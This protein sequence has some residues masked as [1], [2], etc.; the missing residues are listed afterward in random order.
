MPFRLRE[1]IRRL[2]PYIPGKPIEEVQR[3]LG[4]EHVVKLASNENPL[5]PSP[6]AVAAIQSA[7][8]GVSHYPDASGYELKS[9]L[10]ARL[11]LPAPQIVLGNGSDELIH[12]LSILLLEEGDEAVMADPGFPRYEASAKVIGAKPIKVS[13]DSQETHD[14]ERMVGAVNEK[15]RIVW[16]AN[17]NNPTGTIVRKQALDNYFKRVPAHVL[18]VL[19]EAYCDFVD[20][21]SYRTALDYLNEGRPAFGLRTFSKSYGL[22]GM[23]VGYGFGPEELCKPLDCIRPPFNVNSLAQKAALAAL[24]D[25]EH[26]EKTIR[27]SRS[28]VGRL[29]SCLQRHGAKVA[30]SFGNFIWADLGRNASGVSDALMQMGFIVRP[31]SI[32]GRPDCLRISVGTSEELD[33]FEAALEQAMHETVVA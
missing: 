13:L 9:A 7:A 12:Y 26:L 14:L 29:T 8:K 17:P 16:L 27:L 6:K 24:D 30:E 33:R 1:S 20:D 25:Y 4:I 22:A 5:G 32:F 15:T 19:D 31:G 18:T 10:A 28:G 2:A 3:E 21:S 23:R 11:N